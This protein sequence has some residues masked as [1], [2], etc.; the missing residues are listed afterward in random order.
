MLTKMIKKLITPIAGKMMYQKMFESLYVL[1]LYGMNI[2]G[3]GTTEGSGEKNAIRHIKKHFKTC[4]DLVVFDVGAN[5]GHYSN[6]L[7]EVFG[8]K[9]T[10][11][12]FEPSLKTFQKLKANIGDKPGIHLYNHGFGNENAKVTLFSNCDE[13]GLASVYKRRLD[14]FKVNMDKTEEI[15]IK[16]ID[17]FCSEHNIGHINFLKIDVEGHELKVLEGAAN[18][19]SS[20]AIDFIQFEFGGSQI[21]SRVYFQDFYYLLKDKYKIY[22]IVKDGLYPIAKYKEINE[23]FVLT[24]YLAVSHSSEC[25]SR[26]R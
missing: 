18:L 12:S 10:I 3:G 21:D 26:Y 15:E 13:S 9:A 7:L 25:K 20:N 14:H 6:M 2:G 23:V 22:R 1:S 17:A 8:S 16:T 19:L 11:H 5:V 24:N 4:N